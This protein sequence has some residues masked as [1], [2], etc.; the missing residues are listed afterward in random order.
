MEFSFWILNGLTENEINIS[1]NSKASFFGS[2]IVNITN[3]KLIGILSSSDTGITLKYILK[4]YFMNKN[5]A[6]FEFDPNG[7]SNE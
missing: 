7:F 6:Y 2:P 4:E 1:F 3:N 5:N